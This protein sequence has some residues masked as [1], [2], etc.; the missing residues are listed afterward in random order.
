MAKQKKKSRTDY[1]ESQVQPGSIVWIDDK[2]P[3]NKKP[4][5]KKK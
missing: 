4:K 3:K 2:K 1:W 5:N